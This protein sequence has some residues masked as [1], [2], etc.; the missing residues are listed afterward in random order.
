LTLAGPSAPS[1]GPP[2][3]VRQGWAFALCLTALVA[4]HAVLAFGVLRQG[5]GHV[6]E[7]EED[8]IAFAAR[9][10]GQGPELPLSTYLYTDYEAGSLYVAAWTAPF[11]A[12]LGPNVLAVKLASMALSMAM[13]ALVGVAGRR[14]VGGPAALIGAL[15]VAIGP[16]ALVVRALQA[17]GDTSEVLPLVLVQWAVFAAWMHRD[18]ARGVRAPFVLGAVGGL[19]VGFS[20]ASVP[21]QLALVL[22]AWTRR[23]SARA[24]AVA[25]AGAVLGLAV[26]LWNALVHGIAFW[27][28]RGASLSAGIGGPPDWFAAGASLFAR[29]GPGYFVD[30]FPDELVPGAVHLPRLFAL[31]LHGA[32]LVSAAACGREL[33]GLARAV[34][35]GHAAVA[36]PSGAAMLVA[37]HGAFLAAW[38]AT[39][40]GSGYLLA[41]LVPSGALLLGHTLVLVARRGSRVLAAGAC[42]AVVALELFPLAMLWHP[43]PTQPMF[44]APAGEGGRWRGFLRARAALRVPPTHAVALDAV[45]RAVTRVARE[46]DELFGVGQYVALAFDGVESRGALER[47]LAELESPHAAQLALGY[48]YGRAWPGE[49]RHREAI[50]G[51]RALTT[52]RELALH[53]FGRCLGERFARRGARELQR[54]VLDPLDAGDRAAVVFGLGYGYGWRLWHHPGYFQHE[55]L[56]LADQDRSPVARGLVARLA[57]MGP[58]ASWPPRLAE[59]DAKLARALSPEWRRRIPR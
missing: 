39:R 24:W 16:P 26:P 5:L 28:V 11:V 27:N 56:D 3:D 52:H 23:P 43:G 1:G 22:L 41:L 42:T 54:D 12:V 55:I 6:L 35:P 21:F 9:E 25:A 48:G 17:L 37:L 32:W 14:L 57:E 20:L 51:L 13:V 45:V 47:V 49:A 44:G 29:E 19:A 15:V 53:G 58:P 30:D 2:S 33:V 50:L 18:A 40:Y 7:V 31:A 10:L 36:P 8:F 46:P 59:L 38:L 4:G 34:R